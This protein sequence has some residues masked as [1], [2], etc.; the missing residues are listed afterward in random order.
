M[1][2]VRFKAGIPMSRKETMLKLAISI[3]QRKGYSNVTREELADKMKCAESLVSYHFG[4]I[5]K[6]HREIMKAA[7]DQQNLKIIA[8]GLVSQD[9]IAQSAPKKL[10]KHAMSQMV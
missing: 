9:P 8:Q 10:K 7:V 3:A 5:P 4:S 6:L 2:R 1:L